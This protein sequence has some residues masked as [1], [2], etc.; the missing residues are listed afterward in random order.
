[1]QII[2]LEDLTP[3]GKKGDILKASIWWDHKDSS[4]PLFY[5]DASGRNISLSAAAKIEC[6][7]CKH[8]N[9]KTVCCKDCDKKYSSW[10]IAPEIENRPI[11]DFKPVTTLNDP[12]NHPSHYCDGGIEVIDYIDAKGFNYHLGTAIKYISRAGKKGS[13]VEDLKK[14]RWYLDR[15]IKILEEKK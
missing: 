7:T 10:E 15:E 13:T 3:I 5:F 8:M 14:A 4:I 6:S 9:F 11:K 2:L 12:V 1:M